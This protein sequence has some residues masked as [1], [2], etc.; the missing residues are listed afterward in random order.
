MLKL[1]LGAYERA[2]AMNILQSSPD[3]F[4]LVVMARAAWRGRQ[5]FQEDRKI[6]FG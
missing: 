1:F 3:D 4:A 5:S 2:M 6:I